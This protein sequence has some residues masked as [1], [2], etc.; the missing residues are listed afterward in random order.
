MKLGLLNEGQVRTYNDASLRGNMCPEVRDSNIAKLR[1]TG[2]GTCI[3]QTKL[4]L[5]FLVFQDFFFG[6]VGGGEGWLFHKEYIFR[7]IRS[8]IEPIS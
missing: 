6:G 1:K 3:D 4:Y 2:V 7:F 8:V 5:Q